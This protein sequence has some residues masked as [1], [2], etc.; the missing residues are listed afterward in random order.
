MA[1]KFAKTKMR[2]F[3]AEWDEKKYFPVEVMKEAATLGF[4][5]IYW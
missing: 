5:A 3:M 4:A 2:P 1:S